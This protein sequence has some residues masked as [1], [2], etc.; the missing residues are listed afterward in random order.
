MS[1]FCESSSDTQTEPLH[2]RSRNIYDNKSSIGLRL[3]NL[4]I[5]LIKLTYEFF[6]YEL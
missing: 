3:I 1:S 2:N 6:S 5:E 4:F